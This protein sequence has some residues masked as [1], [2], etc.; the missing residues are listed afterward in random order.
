MT[1]TRRLFLRWSAFASAAATAVPFLRGRLGAQQRGVATPPRE[2]KGL[3]TR[4]LLPVAQV[5]LPAELGPARTERATI[6]FARW[7]AN[8]KEDEETLHPYGSDRLGATGGSPAKAWADQLAELDAMVSA[9]DPQRKSFGVATN[10][11]KHE[12][13]AQALAG[14]RLTARVPAPLA[15]PHIA[16]A[17]LS[18]FLESPEAHNLAYQRTIDPKTCRPLAASPK[19]PVALRRAGRS[20]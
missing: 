12:V 14:L 2:L 7:I 8:Y 19:E 5:V 4:R 15:A 1:F 9:R 6:E 16:I 13:L 11:V 3:E 20:A 17:L 10:E 18:R